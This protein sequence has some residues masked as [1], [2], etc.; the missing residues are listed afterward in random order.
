MLL[1]DLRRIARGLVTTARVALRDPEP[2]PGVAVLE[3]AAIARAHATACYRVRVHNP[4]Q[5]ARSLD[6]V[7]RGERS[8]AETPT[9]EVAW[10][11]ALG[12][13]AA[14]DRWVVTD[15]TGAARVADAPPAVTPILSG[16]AAVRWAI[17]AHVSSS[18][19]RLRIE[20]SLVA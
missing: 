13:G 10:S 4:G 11:E 14:A 12:A 7:V 5:R 1:R 19:D 17:E 2:A 18:P 9:F 20:G 3:G 16:D 15:W 8:D 6:V